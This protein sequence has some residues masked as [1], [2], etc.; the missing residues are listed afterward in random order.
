MG[1]VTARPRIPL[2]DEAIAVVTMDQR[3]SRG[4]GDAVR[5]HSADLNDCYGDMLLR[6]F[7]RTAGDE[8]Q[9]VSRD[10]GWLI[11]L[12]LDE[13]REGDWWVGIGIGPYERPL[14]RT[15]RDSRGD[16]F[17]AAREAVEVAKRMPWGFALVGGAG[18]TAAEDCMVVTS[19]VVRRRTERQQ[20]A[21][22][23]FREL[24]RATEAA[25]RIGITPQSMSERLRAAALAEE[26]AGRR[27]A[28]HLFARL[29]ESP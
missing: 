3:G 9:A 14:G 28:A 25:A 13:S 20:E 17:Y 2:P 5:R 18:A 21:V 11:D 15:A 23:C 16:A 1:S 19:A 27:V 7:V 8:M 26:D 22:D 6:R 24:G 12:L 10:V 4:L 29:A